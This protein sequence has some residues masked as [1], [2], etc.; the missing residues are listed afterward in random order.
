MTQHEKMIAKKALMK[1]AKQK[2]VPVE[3]VRREIEKAMFLG[4][5]NQEW[6]VRQTWQSIPKEGQ[7]PTV[8]EVII[9]LAKRSR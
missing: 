5:V 6:A 7:V 4:L 1:L 9:H 3:Q 8:E 2:G